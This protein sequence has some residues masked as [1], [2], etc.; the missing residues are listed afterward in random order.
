MES[1]LASG[2]TVI[3]LLTDGIQSRDGAPPVTIP[4]GVRVLLIQAP[5][6]DASAPTRAEAAA[7]DGLERSGDGYLSS[8]SILLITSSMTAAGN[9]PMNSA[10]RRRQSR[11]FSWSASTTPVTGRPAGTETS[12]G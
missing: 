2:V 10:R 6:S 9:S 8:G 12:K 4:A 11:L 1:L 5:A 7:G 3:V